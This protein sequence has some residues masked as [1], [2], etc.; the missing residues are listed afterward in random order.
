MLLGIIFFFITILL[1]F[2][3]LSMIW[4]PDS[5]WSPWWRTN[6]KTAKAIIRLAKIS[7]KDTVYDLG[8]GDGSALLESGLVGAH[9]VGVEIDPA[10]VWVARARVV[11]GGCRALIQIKRGDLFKTD[12]SDASVVI[13]YLVPKTLERLESKFRKEL[14]PGT[15]I[16]TYVYPLTYFEKISQDKEHNLFLFKVTK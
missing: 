16:I 15:R 3:L 7:R 12:I 4:P 1:L 6:K 10:R 5:P 13:L 14:K 2:I 11:L 9:G 8:C